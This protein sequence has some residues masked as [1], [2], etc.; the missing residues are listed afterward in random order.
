MESPWWQLCSIRQHVA[1]LAW[2]SQPF[3]VRFA[4]L[5]I[6]NHLARDASIPA[7]LPTV[8]IVPM[9]PECVLL[10]GVRPYPQNLQTAQEVEALVLLRLLLSFC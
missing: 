7:T 1:A 2:F 6:H 5:G 3:V 8:S 9:V 10:R 4:G